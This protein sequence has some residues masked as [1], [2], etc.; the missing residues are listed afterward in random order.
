[1]GTFWELKLKKGVDTLGWSMKKLGWCEGRFWGIWMMEPLA[2]GCWM[3][4]I[5]YTCSFELAC[6]QDMPL[7]LLSSSFLREVWGWKGTRLKAEDR[8]TL[9]ALA[10]SCVA[11]VVLAVKIPGLG[12]LGEGKT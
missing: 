9:N 10:P 7:D 4:D 8:G 2:A 6:C 11:G 5:R 3:C 12:N 1:M